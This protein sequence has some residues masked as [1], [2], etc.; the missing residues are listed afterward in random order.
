LTLSSAWAQLEHNKN[1]MRESVDHLARVRRYVAGIAGAAPAREKDWFATGHERFDAAFGGGLARGRIHELFALDADDAASAAGFAAML[2]LRASHDGEPILWLRTDD[3]ERR[4]GGL[5]APGLAELGGAP[6]ALVIAMAPDPVA[7]LR[8]AADSARC[9]GLGALIVECWGKC[10]ALGLTA[11]RRLALAAERSGTTVVMLRAD[12][13]PV[14]SAAETR[15]A[16]SAGGSNGLDANAPGAPLFDIE[17]LRRR[18]GPSGSRWRM[19]WD[20]DRCMFREPALPGDLVSLPSRGPAA[21]QPAEV[22]RL[23]A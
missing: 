7:L 21:P 22:V 12:A 17:L 15:W 11:S 9:A 16:V 4:G 6:G 19:E 10:P 20:R 14:P 18:A 2:A 23:S 5:Y 8:G 13:G 3:A 1:I